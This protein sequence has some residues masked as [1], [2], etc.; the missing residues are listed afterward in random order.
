[1]NGVREDEMVDR[2]Y[3]GDGAESM[4]EKQESSMTLTFA[5]QFDLMRLGDEGTLHP[6]FSELELPSLLSISGHEGSSALE[7]LS[8]SLKEVQD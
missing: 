3:L 2:L 7:H 6:T 8:C 1:M 4:D 5:S